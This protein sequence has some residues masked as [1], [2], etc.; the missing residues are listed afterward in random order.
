METITCG[1]FT[2]RSD[3]LPKSKIASLQN[4]DIVMDCVDYTVLTIKSATC[5]YY[6]HRDRYQPYTHTAR[7]RSPVLGP[8]ASV[9]SW[10][11][12]AMHASQG[13]LVKTHGD[14]RCSPEVYASTKL[15]L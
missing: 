6:A 8:P 10:L 5:S 4:S 15:H 7:H 14:V 2:A 1:I 13:V 11:P 3:I 9:V 12:G